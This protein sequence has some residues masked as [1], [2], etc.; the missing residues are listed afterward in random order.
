MA[1]NPNIDGLLKKALSPETG[2]ALMRWVAEL[3]E[4]IVRGDMMIGILPVAEAQKAPAALR[5]AIECGIDEAWLKLA[6]WLEEPPIGRSDPGAAEE[7]LR[8]AIAR[9]VAGA[10]LRLVQCRWFYRRDDASAAEKKEAFELVRQLTQ[11]N[12]QD[13]EAIYFLGLLTCAGFGTA[14]APEKAVKLQKKAADLGNPDAMFEIYAHYANGLGVAKNDEAAFAA[15]K[16]AAE[17]GHARAMYN[18]GAFYAVGRYVSKDMTEAAIWYDRASDAGNPRA[19]ATLAVM[20]A[21][22]DGVEKDPARAKLLFDEAEYMGFD[23]Q[24]MRDAVGL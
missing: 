2:V 19:T 12:P 6:S 18:M 14:A 3:R 16:R 9:G 8:S 24:T 5:R 23:V 10:Q 1:N 17:A 21:Q 7:V 15:N 20:C 11:A 13:S 4:R 22:G